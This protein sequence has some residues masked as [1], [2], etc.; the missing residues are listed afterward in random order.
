MIEWLDACL[1]DYDAPGVCADV[2]QPV[3]VDI[4][5]PLSVFSPVV[6][7]QADLRIPAKDGNVVPVMISGRVDRLGHVS[8]LLGGG[9]EDSVGPDW[10]NTVRVV[11]LKTGQCVPKDVQRHPQL[12]THWLALSSQG[13]DVVGGALAFLGKELSK[14]SR[15]GYVL[16]PSGAA[17]DPSPATPKPTQESAQNPD[18]KANGVTDSSGESRAEDLAATAAMA[19]VG[20]QIEAHT[21]K[22]CRTYRVEGSC[23]M[24]AE[25][26]RVVS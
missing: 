23:P 22:H 3:R 20:P 1:A 14:R 18:A 25:G 15:D 19:G 11:D 17:L 26:R 4:G 13:L 2:E 5:I 7:Q 21:G 24:Q 6:R 9:S 8:G 12:A 10:N 16:A